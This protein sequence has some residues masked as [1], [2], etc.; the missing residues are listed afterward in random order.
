MTQLFL[1]ILSCSCPSIREIVW[2][3]P[4]DWIR[5]SGF[6]QSG[7][8]GE[9]PFQSR[10]IRQHVIGASE[11]MFTF[12]IWLMQYL[13]GFPTIKLLFSL[14]IVCSLEESASSSNSSSTSICE[15][16]IVIKFHQERY[17]YPSCQMR[18]LRHRE[19]NEFPKSTHGC[20]TSDVG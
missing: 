4:Q 1:E 19:L 14:S 16:M 17:F 10:Q 5:R 18:K 9:V 12:I 13:P 7:L 15:G 2:Y 11:A 6:W 20:M 8:G 3:L